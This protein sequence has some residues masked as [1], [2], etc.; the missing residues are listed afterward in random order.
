MPA[1]ETASQVVCWTPSR[2]RPAP[3]AG[4]RLPADSPLVDP[5]PPVSSSMPTCLSE[6]GRLSSTCSSRRTISV[7]VMPRP[8]SPSGPHR[9]ASSSHRPAPSSACAT[10]WPRSTGTPPR[11][12]R[13]A[14]CSRTDELALEHPE[15]WQRATGR[16]P[17]VTAGRAESGHAA[18]SRSASTPTAAARQAARS[19]PCLAPPASHRQRRH[20][21]Q[22]RARTGSGQTR[23]DPRADRRQRHRDQAHARSDQ[24]DRA[25]QL[26]EQP[27]RRQ[28]RRDRRVAAR[29]LRR[30]RRAHHRG[31]QLRQGT[32]PNQHEAQHRRPGEDQAPPSGRHELRH[33][34]RLALHPCVAHGVRATRTSRRG[35]RC[36]NYFINEVEGRWQPSASPRSSPCP[37]TTEPRPS[38]N[39]R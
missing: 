3:T 26:L 5:G 19:P 12:S 18:A 33:L 25:G 2:A 1:T 24:H 27:R 4:E 34:R 29:L 21:P 7:S 30:R 20:R 32:R 10:T 39:G 8:S 23:A 38:A 22:L 35:S 28:P 14:W 17:N 11:S 9:T 15:A 6:I 13:A 37:R 31:D 36:T 16:P